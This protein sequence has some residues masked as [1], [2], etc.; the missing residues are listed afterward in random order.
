MAVS[1]PSIKPAELGEPPLNG[2]IPPLENGDRLTRAEFEHRYDAMP[3]LK[4]AELIEGVVFMPSP[5][6]QRYH[7]RQHSHL[8]FWLCGYEGRTP[9]VEAG[10][11]STVRLD[12]DNMPQ[13]DCLL[14]IQPEHGGRVRIDEDGYIEGAPDLVAEVASSSASYDLG[15]K[16]DAYRRNGVREYVVWRVL[17]RKVDWYV[18]RGGRFELA[19]PPAD[20]ILRSEVFP[21][22]WLDPAALMRGDVYGVLD[23]VQQGLNTPEHA[24]FVAR[25]G[26]ARTA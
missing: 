13:P 22:L 10:D 19:S 23:I 20:G 21:G 7:G 17:D 9:G 1:T 8:N 5:V 18:N 3:N 25:L 24:D 2:A 26:E 15:K 16:L 6:R 12:L 14:F 4:K 11:N